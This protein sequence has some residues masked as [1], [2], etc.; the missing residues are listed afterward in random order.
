M[1]QTRGYIFQVA[2]RRAQAQDEAHAAE[3]RLRLTQEHNSTSV[4][5]VSEP[6]HKRRRFSSDIDESQDADTS[7]HGYPISVKLSPPTSPEVSTSLNGGTSPSTKDD[8]RAAAIGGSDNENHRDRSDRDTPPEQTTSSRPVSRA[9]KERE[10]NVKP[11]DMTTNRNH[12]LLPLKHNSNG[13]FH[14]LTNGTS[15]GGSHGHHHNNNHKTHGSLASIN[16]LSSPNHFGS[17]GAAAVAAACGVDPV[18]G[19]GAL[20]MYPN[21]RKYKSLSL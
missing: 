10:E 3:E 13:S 19:L 8:L 11:H 5:P 12:V 17:L 21:F 7:Q 18:G 2:V 1:T 20:K 6:T 15:S 16:S 14:K 4:G 9:K